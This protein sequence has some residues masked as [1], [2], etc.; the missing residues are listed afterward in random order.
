[1]VHTAQQRTATTELPADRSITGGF[2]LVS[3]PTLMAVWRACQTKPL[4]I[5]D[6]RAWLACHEI[7]ARRCTAHHGRV[8]VYSFA[9]VANLFG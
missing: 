2:V 5:T 8:P 6:F 7:M 9:E 4:G 3:L 1:M